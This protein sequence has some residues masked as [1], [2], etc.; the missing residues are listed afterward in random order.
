[1]DILEQC[2]KWC[3]NEEYQKIIDTLEAMPSEER[4]PEEDS[5]LARAYNYAAVHGKEGGGECAGPAYFALGWQLS[6]GCGG[7]RMR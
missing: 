3:E 7:A 2:A 6:A 5:E 1:M 4:T